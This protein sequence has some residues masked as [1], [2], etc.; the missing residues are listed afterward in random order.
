MKE[1]ISTYCK[2]FTWNILTKIIINVNYI[3]EHD[4]NGF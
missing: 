4:E 2:I 1:E 3:N